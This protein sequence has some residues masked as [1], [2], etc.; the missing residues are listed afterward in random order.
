MARGRGQRYWDG[1]NWTEQLAPLAAPVAQ[2]D[3]HPASTGDWIG[4]IALSVLIP[5][6]GF[7]VGIVWAAKG[8]KKGTVGLVCIG[9][10]VLAA[11]F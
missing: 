7:I 3:K 11:F 6:A 8:G 4:G 9:V 5:I 2:E 10:S 1:T